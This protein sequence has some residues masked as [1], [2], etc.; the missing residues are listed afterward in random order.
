M[1]FSSAAGVCRSRFPPSWFCLCLGVKVCC[2]FHFH[3]RQVFVFQ[4]HAKLLE[5]FSLAAGGKYSE[6][7]NQCKQNHV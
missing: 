4:S 3:L 5:D 2:S 6:N 1:G 7:T